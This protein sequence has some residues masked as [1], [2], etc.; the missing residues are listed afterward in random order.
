[1]DD[2]SVP[3][4]GFHIR[5]HFSPTG[6]LTGLRKNSLNRDVLEILME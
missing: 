5:D 2:N 1:M 4:L 3:N 6:A